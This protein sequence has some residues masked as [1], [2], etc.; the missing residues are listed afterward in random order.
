M[1]F[2]KE[3]LVDVYKFDFKKFNDHLTGKAARLATFNTN[4]VDNELDINIELRSRNDQITTTI[5]S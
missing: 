5:S 2:T 1:V 4:R 3:K